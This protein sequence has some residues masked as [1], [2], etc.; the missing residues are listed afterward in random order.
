MNTN[1]QDFEAQLRAEGYTEIE[2]KSYDP[3]PANGDHA[4]HFSVLFDYLTSDSFV[5]QDR[6][7]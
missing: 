4:H 2:T 3:R 1:V 5:G 7:T 6:G